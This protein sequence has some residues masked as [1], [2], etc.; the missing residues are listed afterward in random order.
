MRSNGL[1][2]LLKAIRG[3]ASSAKGNLETKGN[4][5]GRGRRER[6]IFPFF[7]SAVVALREVICVS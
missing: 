4:Y 3:G 1:D 5:A 7:R 6:K 2:L